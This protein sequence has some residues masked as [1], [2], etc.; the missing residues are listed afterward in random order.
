[1]W[2]SSS[3]SSEVVNWGVASITLHGDEQSARPCIPCRAEAPDPMKRRLIL[4]ALVRTQWRCATALRSPESS[5][6]IYPQLVVGCDDRLN[7]AVLKE[8]KRMDEQ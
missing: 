6:T 3:V 2:V 5:P 4:G 7:R 8:F 1:M